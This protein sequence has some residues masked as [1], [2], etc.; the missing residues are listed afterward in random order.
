MGEREA[1]GLSFPSLPIC[2]LFYLVC[3]SF[4]SLPLSLSVL[5]I[6]LAASFLPNNS[7]STGLPSGARMG[8]E[9]GQ[10]I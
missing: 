2:L 4:P 5:T 8:W 9:W 10:G 1:H 3:I 6:T 7:G